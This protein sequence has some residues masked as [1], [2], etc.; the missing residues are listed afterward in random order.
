MAERARTKIMW[1]RFRASWK[2]LEELVLMACFCS[3][4]ALTNRA[5]PQ[6]LPATVL[7]A[8]AFGKSQ[9]S[10][11]FHS[12]VLASVVGTRMASYDTT[13]GQS[14][15]IGG[16][17]ALPLHDLVVLI[18]GVAVAQTVSYPDVR[19]TSQCRDSEVSLFPPSTSAEAFSR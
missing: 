12:V 4:Y 8:S 14:R 16:R 15:F 1:P 2:A 10:C 11:S 6:R 18:A 19:L 17:N 9:A 7:K 5:S 3:K 13:L